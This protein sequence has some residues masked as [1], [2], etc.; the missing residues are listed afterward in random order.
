MD[1]RRDGEM[2]K[3]YYY[4]NSMGYNTNELGEGVLRAV[5]IYN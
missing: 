2:L 3:M 5:G 1:Y 4:Y